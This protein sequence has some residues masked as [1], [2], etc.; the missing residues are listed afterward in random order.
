V[1]HDA[2]VARP[3]QW[4]L[5]GHFSFVVVCRWSLVVYQR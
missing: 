1:G 3:I 5:A 2:D 4:C